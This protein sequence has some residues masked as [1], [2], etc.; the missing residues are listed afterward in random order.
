MNTV[1]TIACVAVGAACIWLGGAGW[2]ANVEGSGF[3]FA[4]AGVTFLAIA[5]VRGE[6]GRG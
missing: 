3:V 2:A 6:A 1:I 5:H 4:L